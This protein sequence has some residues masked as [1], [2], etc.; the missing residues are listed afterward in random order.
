MGKRPSLLFIFSINNLFLLSPIAQQSRIL[1]NP[2]RHVARNEA[3]TRNKKPHAILPTKEP[4]TNP[5]TPC[6]LASA[7]NEAVRSLR[8]INLLTAA[9]SV[10]SAF[11]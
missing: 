10:A 11:P 2:L 6:V 4:L 7:K 3:I 8:E 1:S 5:L 9:C